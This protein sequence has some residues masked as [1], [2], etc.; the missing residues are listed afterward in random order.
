MFNN[1]QNAVIFGFSY[2]KGSENLMISTNIL[3]RI[4]WLTAICLCVLLSELPP[5][6]GG[7]YT[8]FGNTVQPE[9]ENSAYWS[10]LSTV[11]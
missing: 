5:S 10:S 2:R 1:I 7:R 9:K 6:Q 4:I 11:C 8:G 3:R